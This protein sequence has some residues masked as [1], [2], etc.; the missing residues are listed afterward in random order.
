MFFRTKRNY[1]I[2]CKSKLENITYYINAIMTADIYAPNDCTG[3]ADKVEI[4]E[5]T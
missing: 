5:F 3:S 4:I 2:K 1:Y